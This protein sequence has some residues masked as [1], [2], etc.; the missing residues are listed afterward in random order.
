[1]GRQSAILNWEVGLGIVN[2]KEIS[3]VS[4]NCRICGY[5]G[6]LTNICSL[7]LWYSIFIFLLLIILLGNGS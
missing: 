2:G 7:V 6:G 5:W 1:M 3:G 4:G